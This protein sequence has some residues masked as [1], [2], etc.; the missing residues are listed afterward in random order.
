MILLGIDPG[1]AS[2]GYAVVEITEDKPRLMAAGVISTKAEELMHDRL[3]TLYER[4]RHVCEAYT[5]KVMIIEKLFFNTNVK[6]AMTVGQ[7]RGISLL[8]AADRKMEVIEYT[9][10]QAK[11]SLT[12]Y[13]RA[14]K[15]EMQEAVKEYMNL[16]EVVKPDDANDALAMALC[17][18][19]KDWN[20]AKKV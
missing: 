19:C 6:T 11:R 10:L 2:T 8:V 1:T 9:A 16:K 14:D 20:H 5:P 13:G 15:K 18:L 3:L 4:L 12:G 7:A 17:Y